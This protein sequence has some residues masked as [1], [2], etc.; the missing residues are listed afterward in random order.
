MEEIEAQCIH[1]SLA[2]TLYVRNDNRG[3]LA[4]R[5]MLNHGAV[6]PSKVMIVK[7]V[8][9]KITLIQILALILAV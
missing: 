8:K 1:M 5:L 7:N 4:P 9:N 2:I 3:S 6:N